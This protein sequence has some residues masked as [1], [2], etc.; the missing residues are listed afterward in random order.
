MV[1]GQADPARHHPP[2]REWQHAK[3]P[4]VYYQGGQAGHN[5]HGFAQARLD[6]SPPPS[7]LGVS[8]PR[9]GLRA[10]FPFVILSRTFNLDYWAEGFPRARQCRPRVWFPRWFYIYAV[11]VRHC[12]IYIYIYIYIRNTCRTGRLTTAWMGYGNFP[13]HH[14]IAW[15]IYSRFDADLTR[16]CVNCA[17]TQDKNATEKVYTLWSKQTCKWARSIAAVSIFTRDIYIYSWTS[18][19]YEYKCCTHLQNPWETKVTWIHR[20]TPVYKDIIWFYYRTT[21]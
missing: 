1:Q 4:S 7:L 6:F 9:P 16:K 15:R 13:I 5:I 20:W 3:S 2:H 10:V 17:R 11:D 14:Y 12:F 19:Q 18:L 8:S 21:L